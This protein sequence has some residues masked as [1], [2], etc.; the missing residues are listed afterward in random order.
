MVICH[1]CGQA[2][3]P[4]AGYTRNKIQCPTCGVI[5]AVADAAAVPPPPDDA[6]DWLRGPAPAAAEPPLAE[7]VPLNEVVIPPN[8]P[9]APPPL[10][11]KARGLLFA[12][13]RCGRMIRRQ[14]EC[15]V[16]D[17]D[18]PGL[19]SPEP[20]EAPASPA[21]P[22]A[23]LPVAR[24]MSLELDD[25]PALPMRVADDDLDEE[26]TP[27]VLADKD[28]P[29][30]PEC[31]RPME[32][33]AVLC[34]RCGYN[35]RTRKKTQRTYEPIE[36]T[37][38]NGL[39]LI[40]RLTW[41]AAMQGG[42]LFLLGIGVLVGYWKPFVV[43]WPFLILLSAFLFG[44]YDRIT[45]RRDRRGRATLIKRW[46]AF[47]IPL[48]PKATEIRGFEGVVTGQW[49]N[50]GFWEWFVWVTLLPWGL[51][52]AVIYYFLVIH[53]PYFFVGLALDH[54]RA[55]VYVY[56][57]RSGAQMGQISDF[58]CEAAELRRLC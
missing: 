36:R 27:Y 29:I 14:R 42:H 11:P 22:L 17:A 38:D 51:I 15:P 13:R 5:C 31:T 32:P 43:S 8:E 18:E 48:A 2:F 21:P 41:F 57:G 35:R 23:P 3:S 28:H 4:P 49:D 24:P 19:L 37:W 20:A 9:A 10:P 50:P 30:C 52:P 12:C 45:I 6:A 53:Q 34:L 44:T 39:P 16:C 54:G 33:G 7:A 47:F 40:G 46:H 58:L 25:E 56:R 1:G 55:A 26:A